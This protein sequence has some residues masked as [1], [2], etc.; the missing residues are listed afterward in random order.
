MP[1]FS[2]TISCRRVRMPNNFGCHLHPWGA[3]AHNSGSRFILTGT[4]CQLFPNE[5]ATF[6]IRGRNL[7]EWRSQLDGVKVATFS[8]RHSCRRIRHCSRREG[9]AYC[10]HR[11]MTNANT[12]RNERVGRG[13]SVGGA[14][15]EVVV[16]YLVSQCMAHSE[17][18]ALG[19]QSRWQQQCLVS[20]G[21]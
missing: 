9:H 4:R 11:T 5:V 1:N 17:G 6:P 12:K 18:F 14:V 20:D 21:S 15:P 19:D 8:V 10:S 3:H 7:S 16:Y 13:K 2:D